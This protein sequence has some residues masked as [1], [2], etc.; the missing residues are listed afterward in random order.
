MKFQYFLSFVIIS[1]FIFIYAYSEVDDVLKVK[2]IEDFFDFKIT[3]L[4]IMA[5]GTL[6]GLAITIYQGTQTQKHAKDS[7]DED[8]KLRFAK[9]LGGFE[10]DL[11]LVLDE[12][13]KL[14]KRST[15]EDCHRITSD[16]L[17]IL[18]R[19]AYLK[20]S[21]KI[22]DEMINYFNYFFSYGLRYMWWKNMMNR[23]E[24]SMQK[25]ETPIFVVQKGKS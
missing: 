20:K 22:D 8:L 2:I 24:R 19:I 9:L 7:L 6:I 1:L 14:T 16:Y 11:Q 21:E 10:K 25:M 4:E 17:N 23:D 3:L 13:R 15:V 18:D 12:E 5:F